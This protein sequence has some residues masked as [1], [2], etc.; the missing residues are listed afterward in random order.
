MNHDNDNRPRTPEEH[1]ALVASLAAGQ[2]TTH[3]VRARNRH[4]PTFARL[5]RAKL[6][7]QIQALERYAEDEGV[8]IP[9]GLMHAANDNTPVD[10]TGR[11]EICRVDSR[12]DEENPTAEEI[13]AAAW[14]DEEDRKE[15]RPEMAT[16]IQFGAHG[17]INAVKVR[18]RYRSLVETFSDPRGSQDG[19]ASLN[20]GYSI[21]DEPTYVQEDAARRLDHAA[22]KLRLGAETCKVLE[23]ACGD[24]TSE[25]IGEMYGVSG[26]A[27]ERL[28]VKL[29]DAAIEKLMADY[30]RRD[31]ADRAA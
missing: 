20:T 26:K 4:W 29:V 21:P 22:M 25:K 1:R 24:A 2:D 7:R 10:E 15:G 12:L 27:A 9:E 14:A 23:L 31:A 19:K 8:S 17:K 16:W 3:E 28:G 13:A 30:A 18:G 5:K 6:W 11:N